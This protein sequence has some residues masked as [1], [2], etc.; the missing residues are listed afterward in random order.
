MTA[1]GAIGVDGEWQAG[2]SKAG[3]LLAAYDSVGCGHALD[4]MLAVHW[5]SLA[6]H[7]VDNPFADVVLRVLGKLVEIQPRRVDV[8]MHLEDQVEAVALQR[9]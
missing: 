8:L 2:L 4:A 7:C 9:G 1:A 6:P 3:Y 5:V